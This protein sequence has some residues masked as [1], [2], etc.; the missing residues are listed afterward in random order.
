MKSLGIRIGFTFFSIAFALILTFLALE[1]WLLF[2]QDYDV[3]MWRYAKELKVDVPDARGYVHKPSKTVEKL[4]G[5]SLRTNQAGFRGPDF[6]QPKPKDVFRILA[7]GDSFTLGWGVKEEETFAHRLQQ[8]LAGVVAGKKVEVLNLGHGNYGMFQEAEL[9]RRVSSSLQ[10]DLV[11]LFF[12]INDAEPPQKSSVGFW[13]LSASTVL[14]KRRIERIRS[15]LDPAFGYVSFYRGL[16]LGPNAVRFQEQLVSLIRSQRSAQVE[17]AVILLPDLRASEFPFK[18]EHQMVKN[19]LFS[20]SVKSLD[21]ADEF[22]Q[23]EPA[24]LWVAPDDPHPNGV[25]HGRIADRVK[26]F[27]LREK[28]L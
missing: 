15:M 27:L 2:H 19:I 21:L 11:L 5:V 16:Y 9:L 10:P 28:L 25:A 24:S 12:Y 4:M 17:T 14:V 7:V 3:E 20:Q 8:K 6:S 26:E 22:T 1:T 13:N 18:N 23:D